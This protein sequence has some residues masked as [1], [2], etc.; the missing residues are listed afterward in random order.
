MPPE[1]WII[2][3][4]ALI[5]LEF[6]VPG[7][8]LVFLGAS[9]IIVGVAIFLGY[10]E[11]H[12]IPFFTFAI[13]SVAMIALLRKRIKTWFLGNTVSEENP[14]DLDDIV[15]REALVTSGFGEGSDSGNVEFKGANWQAKAMGGSSPKIGDRVKIIGQEGITLKIS[16]P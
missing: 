5:L 12:G 14:E 2:L 11:A 13:L 9:A 7:V 6:V 3:G 10:P 1:I 4:F 8:L 15:G 16:K